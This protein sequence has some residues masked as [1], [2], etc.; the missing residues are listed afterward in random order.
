VPPR[1]HCRI[2]AAT[3]APGAKGVQPSGRTRPAWHRP[4]RPGT[5][6]QRGGQA[7]RNEAASRSKASVTRSRRPAVLFDR[8]TAP[9]VC[10]AAVPWDGANAGP[11]A[12][13][14]RCGVAGGFDERVRL[15]SAPAKCACA[16]SNAERSRA[17]AARLARMASSLAASAR[18]RRVVGRNRPARK[19]PRSTIGQPW[20]TWRLPA[21]QQAF[22]VPRVFVLIEKDAA[23][24]PP[25]GP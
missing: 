14:S 4:Q 21:T 22:H 16:S 6:A 3:P 9:S 10:V 17:T 15:P 7:S 8:A 1:P 18:S 24:V 23:A 13:P 25:L 12:A 2:L 11:R 19:G 20:T 5:L